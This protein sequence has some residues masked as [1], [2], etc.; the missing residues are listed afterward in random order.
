MLALRGA[1]VFGQM[2]GL[3]AGTRIWIAAA[4]SIGEVEGGLNRMTVG[5]FIRLIEEQQIP[6]K[7][8]L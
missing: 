3:P 1:G 7:G 6:I 4:H 5:R 8:L 2:I